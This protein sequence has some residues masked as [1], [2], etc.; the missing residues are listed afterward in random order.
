MM[1]M[2]VLDMMGEDQDL[3]QKYRVAGVDGSSQPPRALFC[4]L[5]QLTDRTD[6]NPRNVDSPACYSRRLGLTAHFFEKKK[7]FPNRYL[8][9]GYKTE[10]CILGCIR[11]TQPSRSTRDSG[12]TVAL[13]LHGL[14]APWCR[15][16]NRAAQR[17]RRRATT[18]FPFSSSAGAMQ[19]LGAAACEWNL[20]PRQVPTWYIR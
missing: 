4:R 13:V 2:K 10:K 6:S 16:H 20:A 8:F 19:K 12:P 7:N 17:T 3:I 5:W 18:F 14:Q 11:Y 15:C 9:K 1:G